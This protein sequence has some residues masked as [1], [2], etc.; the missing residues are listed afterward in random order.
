MRISDWSSD[1]CSSDLGVP[2]YRFSAGERRG[3]QEPDP[4]AERG[5]MAGTCQRQFLELAGTSDEE[6]EA[7]SDQ[8]QAG[9]RDRKSVG[10]GKRGSVRVDLGGGRLIKNKTNKDNV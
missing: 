3:R 5:T 1:V 2:P 9:L 7:A 10:S 4:K 6:Q 8:R